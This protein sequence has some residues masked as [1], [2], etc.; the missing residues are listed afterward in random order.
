MFLEGDHAL[1]SPFLMRGVSEAVARIAASDPASR[2][3]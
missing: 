2:M 3:S 1:H